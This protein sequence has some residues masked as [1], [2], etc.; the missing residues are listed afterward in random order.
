[1]FFIP[2]ASGLWSSNTNEWVDIIRIK[3][4]LLF[5]PIA[6]A[7]SWQL[8]ERQWKWVGYF[9][10]FLLCMGTCYSLFH[11]IQNANALHAGYL[12]SKTIFTPLD[13]DHVRFS[14]LAAAG[15][16]LCLF[17]LQDKKK[18][19]IFFASIALWLGIFLHILAARTG[20]FF[21]IN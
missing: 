6:F 10:L 21:N 1:M 2:F 11:Y 20:F 17:F 19:K 5:L 16:L 15:F 18:Y 13:N 8:N 9:F 14:L 3:L 4:P 12:K 7:G